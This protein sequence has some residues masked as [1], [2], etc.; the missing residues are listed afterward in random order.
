MQSARNLPEKTM[1]TILWRFIIREISD[2]SDIE[3]EEEKEPD[4]LVGVGRT[5]STGATCLPRKGREQGNGHH[6]RKV[7]RPYGFYGG[8]VKLRSRA[9]PNSEDL[10]R[11]PAQEK[12]E[13]SA[14]AVPIIDS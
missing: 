14:S 10:A 1:P 13:F 4:A 9:V 8:A 6:H 5:T 7:H 3:V 12:K 2:L 11:R